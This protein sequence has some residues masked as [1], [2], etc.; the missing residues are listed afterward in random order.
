MQNQKMNI[1][2]VPANSVI[3]ITGEVEFSRIRSKIEGKE[4]EADNARK[5]QWGTSPESKPHTRI[6]IKN[7]AIVPLSPESGLTLA[8]QFCQSKFYTSNKNAYIAFE[9]KSKGANLPQLLQRSPTNSISAITSP[10]GELAKGLRATLVCKILPATKGKNQG[11][12]LEAV[13]CEEPARYYATGASAAVLES[14]IARGATIEPNTAEAINSTRVKQETATATAT[15]AAPAGG[16]AP[17]P[18]G[19]ASA[20]APAYPGNY[21]TPV[22]GTVMPPPPSNIV[23]PSQPAAPPMAQDSTPGVASYPP[24]NVNPG[25]NL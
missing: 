10:E 7:P 3:H 4:L 12:T 5:A 2:D 17:P 13:I 24:P 11:L 15:A 22:A 6:V 20:Q 18:Y 19:S 8:E 1:N 21:A 14:L 16:L 25:V 9:G 23:A